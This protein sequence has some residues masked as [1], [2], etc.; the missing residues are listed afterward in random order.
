MENSQLAGRFN[1]STWN[2]VQGTHSTNF[3]L[4]D[5]SVCK[6]M[7]VISSEI[8]YV[9]AVKLSDINYGRTK[10]T[11]NMVIYWKAIRALYCEEPL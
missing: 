2:I 8:N 1:T 7:M 9:N 10:E 11:E 6:F 4:D 3:Y 5:H